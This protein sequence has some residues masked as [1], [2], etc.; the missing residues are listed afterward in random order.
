MANIPVKLD[1]GTIIGWLSVPV[2]EGA[3]DLGRELTDEANRNRE[4]TGFGFFIGALC[5]GIDN[6][7]ETWENW[8]GEVPE[9]VEPKAK[10]ELLPKS[11]PVGIE[12]IKGWWR[13]K[14]GKRARR[15]N[16]DLKRMFWV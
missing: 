14:E 8:T 13:S 16:E 5:Q 3:V 9:F 15:Q 7:R 10:I 12:P 2:G 11:R 1:D 6:A 4:H